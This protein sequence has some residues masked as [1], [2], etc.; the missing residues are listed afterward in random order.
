[1]PVGDGQHGLHPSSQRSTQRAPAISTAAGGKFIPSPVAAGTFANAG[2]V[3]LSATGNGGHVVLKG[4][5]PPAKYRDGES[6]DLV[7]YSVGPS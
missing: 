5:Y 7:H 1:M 3:I 4:H 6:N 2:D